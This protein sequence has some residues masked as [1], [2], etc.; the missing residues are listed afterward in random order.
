M[1]QPSTERG[2][3]NLGKIYGSLEYGAEAISV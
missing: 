1:V 2:N 3:I